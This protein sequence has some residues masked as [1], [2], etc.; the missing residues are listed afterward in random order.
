[1]LDG[2]NDESIEVLRKMRLVH[3]IYRAA[4]A[5]RALTAS[6]QKAHECLF[7]LSVIEGTGAFHQRLEK[8]RQGL[9]VLEKTL[10]FLDMAIKS[11][12][13]RDVLARNGSETGRKWADSAAREWEDKTETGQ[14]WVPGVVLRSFI[15]V[16]PST[17]R[18]V[19]LGLDAMQLVRLRKIARSNLPT[20]RESAAK[21]VT[22]TRRGKALLEEL[23]Q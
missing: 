7:G 10:S 13:L 12:S 5:T 21:S 23:A 1:M 22:I 16:E 11:E 9:I 4:P 17:L 20:P 8:S 15:K 19:L 18:L 3:T 6:V 14:G 2:L